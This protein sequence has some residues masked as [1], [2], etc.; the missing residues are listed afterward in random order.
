MRQFLTPPSSLW[1][2]KRGFLSAPFFARNKL[3]TLVA[4]G[5]FLYHC[6]SL[7]RAMRVFT[8]LI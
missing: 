4:M 1:W 8:T 6:A 3:K 5:H 2:F 7:S